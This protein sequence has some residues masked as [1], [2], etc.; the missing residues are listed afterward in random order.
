MD[1]SIVAAVVASVTGLVAMGLLVLAIRSYARR[2]RR[3]HLFLGAA[4]GI[5]AAKNILIAL[6]M[7]VFRIHHDAL[8]ALETTMDLVVILLLVL[9]HFLNR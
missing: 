9:P 8:W 1:L 2:R 5:F 4:F 6:S 7:F 3:V